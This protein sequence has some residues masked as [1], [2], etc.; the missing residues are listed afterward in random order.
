MAEK[1]ESFEK[2]LDKLEQ[3]VRDLEAGELPLEE[4]LK[5]FEKGIKLSRSCAKRLDAA[6]RRIEEILKDGTTEALD[7]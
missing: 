4:A 1:K 2:M 7:V 6:E 3:V 5:H